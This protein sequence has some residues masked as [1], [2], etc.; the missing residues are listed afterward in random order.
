MYSTWI[1]RV[2]G[3]QEQNWTSINSWVARTSTTHRLN[4]NFPSQAWRSWWLKQDWRWNFPDRGQG[5][6]NELL[7]RNN[8][9]R[10]YFQ[11][12]KNY[13]VKTACL[14][15]DLVS[16]TVF[17]TFS[18]MCC[19]WHLTAPSHSIHDFRHLASNSIGTWLDFNQTK[20]GVAREN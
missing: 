11:T 16:T 6:V 17:D 7:W 10:F 9:S 20:I 15:I 12:C 18:P 5:T 8:V 13:S 4:T 19:F 1:R 2:F 3:F 14:R